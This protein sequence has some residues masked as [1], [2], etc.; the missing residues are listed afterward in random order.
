VL[1]WPLKVIARGWLPIV[2]YD[3]DARL[4]IVPVDYVTTA[5]LTLARDR[6][7]IGRTY[8]L[9]AGPA[10]DTTAGA[11]AAH[12]AERFGRRLPVRVRPIW[13]QRLVRPALMLL[14]APELR[15][16]LRTGLIYRPYIQMRLRF[17]TTQATACLAPQG[18]NCPPVL[19]YIDTIVD[20]ALASDFGRRA[21]PT[22]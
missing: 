18:V 19:E 6:E 7:T 8:H 5:V 13:W 22:A 2:P 21:V 9:A 20:A 11:L 3:P 14:P 12:V 10:C 1:Y 15:R 17:D 16:T 4:D